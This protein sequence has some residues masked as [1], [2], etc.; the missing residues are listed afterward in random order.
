M[1]IFEVK[2]ENLGE[3]KHAEIFVEALSPMD[4]FMSTS[5]LNRAH[6]TDHKAKHE[7]L[8]PGLGSH[9]CQVIT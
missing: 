6:E 7:Q 3:A 4:E 5:G 1:N 2:V 9:C 8:W